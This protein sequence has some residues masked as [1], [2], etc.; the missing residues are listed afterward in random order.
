MP[1]EIQQ[2]EIEILARIRRGERIER[3]ESIRIHKAGHRLNI[4]LT[5]SP[6]RDFAGKIV[7]AAK[8]AHDV[9][10][11]RQIEKALAEEARAHEVLYEVGQLVAAQSDLEHVVQTVTDAATELSGARFGAFFYNVVDENH[12]AYWLYTLSGVPRDAFAQFPNPRSTAV[13][14]PTFKG[15]GRRGRG[16]GAAEESG[17]RH[18]GQRHRD[19]RPG[20]L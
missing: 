1:P 8:I 19:A 18:P 3:F 2:E 6:V 5:I 11:R 15:E 16:V 17:V 12:E 14:A 4:S 7:G 20:W 10:E 9:T 13:F